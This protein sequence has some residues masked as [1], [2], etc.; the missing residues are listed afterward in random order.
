MTLTTAITSGVAS[1]FFISGFIFAILICYFAVT[2]HKKNTKPVADVNPV[3]EE[4]E[5]ALTGMELKENEAYGS[6]GIKLKDNAAYGSVK[7]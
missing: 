7:K 6:P 1:L 5:L 3:Y 4:I 2:R